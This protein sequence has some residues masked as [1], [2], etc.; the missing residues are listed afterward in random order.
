MDFSTFAKND[1]EIITGLKKN[2]L[3]NL[4]YQTNVIP[5]D[6][7]VHP[8]LQKYHIEARNKLLDNETVDWATAEAIAISSLL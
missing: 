4:G 2:Y 5:P 8:R 1:S 6:F 7:K 3:K